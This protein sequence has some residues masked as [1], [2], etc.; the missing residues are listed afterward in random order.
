MADTPDIP[1]ASGPIDV[2]KQRWIYLGIS[3]ALLLPGILFMFLSMEK[4]DTHSPIRLG[5]DFTGGTLLEL[6]FEKPVQQ[7]DIPRIRTVFDNAGLSGSVIQIQ[8][9]R[10]GMA[11]DAPA[12]TEAP[13]PAA[14]SPAQPAAPEQATAP[15]QPA[16]TVEAPTNASAIQSIVS[17]RSKQIDEAQYTQIKSALQEQLGTY[18]LLQ[19]NSVGPTLASELLSNGLIALL[20]A[21]VLIVGYLT[22]RFQF[23]YAMCAIVALVH[24]TL[25]VFG[26]FAIL[27]YLF[28]T[29]VDSLFITGILTVV[30]FSVHDTIVVFDRLRENAKRYY[31]QKLPF[32]TIA[33]ISVNQTLT[34]SINTSLTAL[35]TLVALYF[36]GGETTRDF[37]LCM[38]LGI[39]VGTYS[40]IFVASTILVWWRE[41]PKAGAPRPA[42]SAA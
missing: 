42:A 15:A 30:G 23:D 19:R 7:E 22:F 21:Y 29:E 24:D 10:E 1:H 36:F 25:T 38:I 26:A 40:S 32:S 28:H 37:V 14:A 35:L 41:R 27:G 39:A 5:I 17:I 31:S 4:Y 8:E 2:V 13:Q 3:L 34:R 11:T 18:Q 20:L 6:G 33:N 12:A 9:P 16:A